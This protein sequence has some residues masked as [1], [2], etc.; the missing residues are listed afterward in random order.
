[1]EYLDQGHTVSKWWHQNG[2]PMAH[3]PI[4]PLHSPGLR[5]L[6]YQIRD[7]RLLWHLFIFFIIGR[8][9]NTWPSFPHNNNQLKL[10]SNWPAA[11]HRQ[12]S[13]LPDISCLTSARIIHP[14]TN[15]KVLSLDQTFPWVPW[16]KQL[17]VS[18]RE[19]KLYIIK[20]V[21]S[22]SYVSHL[23]KW[24]HHPV[25]IQIPNLGA[26]PDSFPS[27]DDFSVNPRR[28]IGPKPSISYL[29]TV[30]SSFLASLC[31][32]TCSK[33]R[34][35]FQNANQILFFCL[36]PFTPKALPQPSMPLRPSPSLVLLNQAPALYAMSQPYWKTP[37]TSNVPFSMLSLCLEHS[38][39]CLETCSSV[40]TH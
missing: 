21:P 22:T 11:H 25:S 9:T 30:P 12:P 40:L 29:I 24:H 17:D 7:W 23:R 37:D 14:S 38:H 13:S 5:F 19:R 34:L 31:L 18:Q 16:P 2:N 8:S 35:I 3:L 10:S 27:S 28:R 15:P 4:H 39:P 20:T 36:R 33:L 32:Q 1:M 26:T 6:V